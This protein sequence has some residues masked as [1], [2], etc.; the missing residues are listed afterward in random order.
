MSVLF[1]DSSCL[2][3]VLGLHYEKITDMDNH[4]W[5]PKWPLKLSSSVF[6][7]I[8]YITCV[9]V[10]INIWAYCQIWGTIITLQFVYSDWGS[11]RPHWH[12]EGDKYR[13][14]SGAH[15]KHTQNGCD[16]VEHKNTPKP[17]IF[18]WPYNFNFAMR[19]SRNACL[20]IHTLDLAIIQN[21]AAMIQT[22]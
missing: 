5:N 8:L 4:W 10:V 21:A 1:K 12:W 19:I 6:S 22:A 2:Y 7:V 16:K 13:G 20:T 17:N 11:I 18:I 3:L 15:T 14:K 9:F